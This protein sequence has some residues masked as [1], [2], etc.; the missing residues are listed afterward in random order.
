M[1]TK[2]KLF[3]TLAVS[4]VNF[5]FKLSYFESWAIVGILVSIQFAVNTG[6]VTALLSIPIPTA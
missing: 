5:W 6:L 1:F 4:L 3:I 2:S